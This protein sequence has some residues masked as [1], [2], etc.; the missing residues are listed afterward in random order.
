MNK[1]KR[2][3]AGIIAVSAVMTAF[4]SCEDKESTENSQISDTEPE[5][6][7]PVTE[8]DKT[9]ISG[10]T[11]YWVADYDLNPAAGQQRSTA[12]AI[13]EDTYG[14]KIE[15]IKADPT[16]KFATVTK[17][18]AAGEPV[19]MLP[20]EQ[21]S[22][23]EGLKQNIYQPL[24]S[25]FEVMSCGGE[26]D[27]WA[28]MMDVADMFKHKDEHYVMPYSVSD[29]LVLIYSRKL[30]KEFK[31]SDPYE[32]YTQGKWD[33]DAMSEAMKKFKKKSEKKNDDTRYGI[34]GFFG[35][36]VIQ[37]TGVS[38]VS[39]NNGLLKSNLNS[40]E[41]SK[42]EN[43]MK[44]IAEDGLYN[45]YLYSSYPDDESTLFYAAGTWALGESNGRN[46]GMDLMVVPFPKAPK[47][48]DSYMICDYNA[49]MLAAGAAS[50][51]A[52]ATYIK[53]ERLAATDETFASAA[54]EKALEV[55][56]SASGYKK[57]F[58]TEEQYDAIQSF[59]DTSAFKPVYEYSYGM[60]E[61]MFGEG[62]FTADTRGAINNVA[63]LLLNG[64]TEEIPSWSD[65]KKKINPDVDA[66]VNSYNN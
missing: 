33:W 58:V 59:L 45:D 17:R 36:A 62:K 11:I 54:K 66:A 24:D 10:Q 2:M 29:P 53:C 28:D 15:Y 4:A 6:T 41:L 7:E 50:P 14:G 37:S 1:L 21:G 51:N 23:P 39:N 40:S 26:E 38:L 18:K 64:G 35:D 32:L 34:C 31:V 3:F 61:K 47:T 55:V 25:Y 63:N 65:L 9:D 44:Q 8:V 42:A 19:D 48:S 52:V 56:N 13:F 5:T 46:E 22:V 20:F 12:L 43:F 27:I 49:K 16:E 60:G 57:S 30:A